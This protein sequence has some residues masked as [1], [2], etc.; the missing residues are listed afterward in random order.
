MCKHCCSKLS[1]FTSRW[2]KNFP[3]FLSARL[4]NEMSLVYMQ[5]SHSSGAGVERDSGYDSLGRMNLLDR[6]TQTLLLTVSEEEANRLL[7]KQRPEV[8]VHHLSM[9]Q[10]WIFWKITQHYTVNKSTVN[11]LT[12]DPNDQ[13]FL[14]R[15][16]A[17]LQRRFLSVHV[18]DVRSDVGKLNKKHKFNSQ[19]CA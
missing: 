9:S 15:I 12:C 10:W 1:I 11:F 16:S 4:E 5:S 19:I 18:E 13:R 6:L 3:L 8:R 14:V 7:L 2:Q 17:A